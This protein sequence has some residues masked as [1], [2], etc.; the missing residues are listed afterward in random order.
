MNRIGSWKI[1]VE[2]RINRFIQNPE[3]QKH[4]FEPMSKVHRTIIHDVADIAGLTAFSFGEEEV[5]RY[6]MVFKKEFAPLDDELAAYRKGEEWDPEKAKAVARQKELAAA[7]LAEQDKESS[8]GSTPQTDYHEKYEKLLGRESGKDAAKITTPNKQFGF[9]KGRKEEDQG[10]DFYWWLWQTSFPL[11]Q[12]HLH[13]VPALVRA[14]H[15]LRDRL[16][17]VELKLEGKQGH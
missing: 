11:T 2:D 12:L 8:R 14:L 4:K 3:K 15:S 1:Q 13:G 9:E 5:D 6:V 7:A 16:L 17:V 10:E